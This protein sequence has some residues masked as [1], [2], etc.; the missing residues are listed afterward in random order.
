[1][2]Q[3]YNIMYDFLIVGAG[4]GGC[5]IAYFLQKSGK[6]VAIIDREGVAGGASGVAGAFLSPLPGKKNSYNSLVNNALNFSI[7]FYKKLTPDSI[8]QKGILR[9]PNE[10]FKTSKLK[11]NHIMYEFFDKKKLQEISKSFR[12]I[13]GYF[14]EEGAMISPLE[15]CHKLIDN[16]DFYQKDLKELKFKDG[17]YTA[18]GLK[19]KNI[20]Y[21]VG[22]SKPL[23]ATPYLNISPIFGLRI[24][25]KTT[26]K[27]LFN[28][29]KSITIS[30]NRKDN[31]VA[32]GAT[33]QRHDGAE[34]ECVT[35]CANCAFY[36]DN[37]KQQI[38]I[39]LKQ[40]DEL[41]NLENL[42]VVKIYKGARASIKSYFP[43]VG[44]VIDFYK[45]LEKYPSIKNGTKIPPNLLT[46]FPN[47]YM[48]N[49]LGSRG[50]VFAPYL[51]KILSEN[52][53]NQTKIPDEIS[54]EKLFYKKARE[55][56]KK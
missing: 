15:I 32:I 33:H 46:Y 20:I 48:M 27:V 11:D 6:K 21:A 34:S 7:D 44:K 19:A 28:I 35:S 5:S 12:N 26:T 24:D 14:Y 18:E 42:E 4:A 50:F 49:A 55:K 38:E 2:R 40:A 29:H 37:E 30:T 41:I 45:S 54:I 36:V 23:I 25:V 17:I 1:M 10:N 52:I 51:A 8:I 53:L 22:V 39:L 3:K 47:F 31:L 13:E 16:C 56:A 43:V 9:V